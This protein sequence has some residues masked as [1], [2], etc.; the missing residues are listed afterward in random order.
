MKLLFI[1]LPLLSLIPSTL[2][3]NGYPFYIYNAFV[4][5]GQNTY[6]WGFSHDTGEELPITC[7]EISKFE[8]TYRFK[9]EVS[10]VLG[11]VREGAGCQWETRNAREITRFEFHTV[12]GHYI[13]FCGFSVGGMFGN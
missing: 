13:C 12:W 4:H 1:L 8:H 10:K 6:Y 9:S 7:D 11:T 2:A 3:G 5:Q